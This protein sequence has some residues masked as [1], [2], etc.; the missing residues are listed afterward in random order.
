MDYY[1][2]RVGA[3]PPSPPLLPHYDSPT[4]QPVT[5][6]YSSVRKA[7]EDVSLI[8]FDDSVN[9]QNTAL[10]GQSGI[11]SNALPTQGVAEQR[12]EGGKMGDSITEA[13]G[14]QVN[15]DLDAFDMKPFCSPSPVAEQPLM[16]MSE[17]WFHGK[18][19][20]QECEQLLVVDGAFLV[21]ESPSTPGQFVLS[22]RNNGRV[23][24]LLLV[25][26]EGV[27][28][29]KDHT[30]SSVGHLVDFHMNSN[31]PIVSQEAELKLQYPVLQASHS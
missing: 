23:K 20:R 10:V 5:A 3:R 12:K 27:V 9:G 14:S 31:I 8:N 25:D 28:R 15:G 26:P 24:H 6:V 17:K 1:N 16:T 4:A 22:G 13:P 21:R 29:T 30:F 18:I 19:S 11:Y 2:D 7:H